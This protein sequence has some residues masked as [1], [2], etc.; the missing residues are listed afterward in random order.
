MG[1]FQFP[2]LRVIFF[3][4]LLPLIIFTGCSSTS[5]LVKGEQLGVEV[6]YLK[7]MDSYEHGMYE[8]AEAAFKRIVED[9]S[10]SPYAVDARLMLADVYYAEEKYDDAGAQYTT[11][12]TF[13]PSHPKAPYALFQKGMGHLKEVLSIDR[14]QGSTRKALFA[15]EDLMGNYPDSPYSRKARE[16]IVFLK[17]RLAQRELYVGGF[18]FKMKN[19]KGALSRFGS[20]LKDYSDTEVVDEALYY[21]GESYIMLGERKR[22]KD[23]F[24]TLVE[25]YPG[26]PYTAAAKNRL[27]E[28]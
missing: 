19:Y 2:D 13:H 22:A 16:M 18:Y 3:A 27:N 9:Y 11:F 10:L 8:E 21:I 24:S 12:Y 20:V 14:D 28:G 4:F 23:A 17:G 6:S 15:F 26:S 7:G 1:I 5:K 25:E